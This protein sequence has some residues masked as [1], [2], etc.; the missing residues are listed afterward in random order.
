MKTITLCVKPLLV[1]T[2]LCCSGSMKGSSWRRL[3]K[4]PLTQGWRSSGYFWNPTSRPGPMVDCSGVSS[5]PCFLMLVFHLMSLWYLFV[6]PPITLHLTRTNKPKSPVWHVES[7]LTPWPA[8]GRAFLWVRKGS[9]DARPCLC[10]WAGNVATACGNIGG[11]FMERSWRLFPWARSGE[12]SA[13]SLASWLADNRQW[14]RCW[15]DDA[16]C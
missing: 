4:L 2:F 16:G 1:W 15:W 14:D 7:G 12:G 3:S 6:P 8:A 9:S 13:P 11:S 10:V 5:W